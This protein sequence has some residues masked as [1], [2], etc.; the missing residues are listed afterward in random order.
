MMNDPVRFC[1]DQAAAAR[2]KANESTPPQQFFS[3]LAEQWLISANR[4]D[5][6]QRLGLRPDFH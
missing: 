4:F 5:I 6:A 1:L 2:L 3:D